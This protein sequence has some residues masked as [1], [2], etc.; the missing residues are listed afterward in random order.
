MGK[1]IISGIV[2]VVIIYLL[3]VVDVGDG[4][5]GPGVCGNIF[6]TAYDVMPVIKSRQPV[7]EGHVGKLLLG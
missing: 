5:V 3:E 6:E 1:D 7:L 4:D 2:A